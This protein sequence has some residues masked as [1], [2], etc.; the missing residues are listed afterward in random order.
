MSKDKT[1]E[2]VEMTTGTPTSKLTETE[3]LQL[4]NIQLKK[5]LVA[6]QGEALNQQQAEWG[7]RVKKRL[8]L[9]E[10]ANLKISPDGSVT[11]DTEVRN[12]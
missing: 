1:A 7:A 8:E 9:P 2:V 4:E 10:D 3:M 11:M 12:G 5:N 6:S